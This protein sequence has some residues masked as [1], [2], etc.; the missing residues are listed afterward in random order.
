MTMVMICEICGSFKG[1]KNRSTRFGTPYVGCESCFQKNLIPWNDAVSDVLDM[2]LKAMVGSD[3]E[4]TLKHYG[5]THGELIGEAEKN[6]DQYLRQLLS[7][8]EEGKEEF[9][10]GQ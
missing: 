1:V 5:K 6:E 9:Q 7:E 8:R 10:H 2:G 4:S 3:I